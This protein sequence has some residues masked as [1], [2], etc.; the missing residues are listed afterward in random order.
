MKKNGTHIV[1]LL[2]FHLWF[3]QAHAGE[4]PVPKF[5][6][7][8]S[9]QETIYHSIGEQRPDGYVID[10]TLSAYTQALPAGFDRSLSGLGAKDRW[11][12]IGAGEGQAV[13][14]YA[15]AVPPGGQTPPPKAQ[16]VAMSIEDRRTPAWHRTAA[17]LGANQISYLSN[18]RLGEYSSQELGR[19][20]VISDVIGGFSYTENLSV[21]MEK[22]LSL[23][24]INGSFYTVLQDVQWESGANKPFYAGATFLTT[25]KN[26][27]GAEVKVC[28]WLKSIS[29]VEVSCEGKTGWR[30]PIENYSVRKVCN[31][32]VVPTLAPTHYVAGTPPERAFQIKR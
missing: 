27:D 12:D 26:A 20:Q 8:R 31:D 18:K 30:P 29:C 14:D 21:F 9:K 6:E 19:F 15:S 2:L 32:V 23:L 11:L 7:E 16:A 13:L 4:A 24:D 5:N 28:A 1:A 25:I 22:V 17:V 10:R 3:G